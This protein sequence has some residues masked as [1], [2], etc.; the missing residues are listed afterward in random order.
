[1]NKRKQPET[2]LIA[3]ENKSEESRQRDYDDI[4]RALTAIGSGHYEDVSIW[5]GWKDI[6]KSARRFNE[7]REKDLIENTGIKKM[8]SRHRPAFIHQL[9]NVSK[10]SATQIVDDIITN[11]TS[12]TRKTLFD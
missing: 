12:Q 3:N 10:K 2:S 8:T 1:M 9:C 4:V 6:A 7:M 11:A 5:L